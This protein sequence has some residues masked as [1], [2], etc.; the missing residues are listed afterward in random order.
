MLQTHNIYSPPD[1]IIAFT[2]RGRALLSPH[3]LLLSHSLLRDIAAQSYSFKVLFLWRAK[4]VVIAVDFAR[5]NNRCRAM[6]T[7]KEKCCCM[8]FVFLLHFISLP[9]RYLLFLFLW[10]IITIRIS[11]CVSLGWLFWLSSLTHICCLLC[12][13]SPSLRAFVFDVSLRT[14]AAR[15][16]RLIALYVCS[17]MPERL[18]CPWPNGDPST[19]QRKTNKC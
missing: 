13:F 1:W 6:E 2:C 14:T 3:F 11:V 16:D 12:C 17:T 7:L 9:P 4:S 8:S 5:E 15:L 18:T 19:M 10:T